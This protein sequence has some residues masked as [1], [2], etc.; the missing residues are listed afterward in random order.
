M[1]HRELLV[2]HCL[3]P[4]H[5]GSGEGTGI[6]DRP[7]IREAATGFPFI[8]GSTIKGAIR[9]AVAGELGGVGAAKDNK[10]FGAAFGA[11]FG[12]GETDGNRGCVT[13]TDASLLLF[14]V[15]SLVNV[16]AWA[17]CRLSLHRLR[18]FGEMT[19]ALPT[20]LSE[21]LRLLTGLGLA[22]GT[23]S[24]SR[25][26]THVRSDSCGLALATGLGGDAPICLEGQVLAREK[27]A[28]NEYATKLDEVLA[29]IAD[30]AKLDPAGVKGR[31]VLVPDG[32]FSH[33]V[34]HCTQVE[35][36]IKIESSG[37][38]STGSLR[39]TEFLPVETV[40][41]ALLQVEHPLG[42]PA[43]VDIEKVK[44]LLGLLVPGGGEANIQ[45]GGDE[46]KGKGIVRIRRWAG[47]WLTDA[48]GEPEGQSALPSADT[49]AN[50]GMGGSK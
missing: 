8:Q 33:F 22:S 46:S 23:G 30:M 50:A 20:E 7:I 10:D 47:P 28:N 3:T 18:R 37:V 19:S 6:I 24:G 5:N 40:L 34:E 36:N 16:F 29:A 42:A 15:R 27:G 25:T 11:A 12:V 41:F 17:T 43:G 4:L 2:V 38:T 31:A 13:F 26:A 32:E 21:S 48:N 44:E 39:Y 49:R 1:S 9:A 14:P 45:L 35:A